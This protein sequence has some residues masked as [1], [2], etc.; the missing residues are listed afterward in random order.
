MP[1]SL[2]ETLIIEY[3]ETEGYLVYNNLKI[4]KKRETAKR[5]GD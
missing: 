1:A 4:P 3:L 2:Y 5:E